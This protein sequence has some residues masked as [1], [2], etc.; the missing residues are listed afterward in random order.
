MLMENWAKE[1]ERAAEAARVQER[2]ACAKLTCVRCKKD[3]FPKKVH[4]GFYHPAHGH[5]Y[6]DVY[7]DG[8]SFFVCR[9]QEIYMRGERKENKNADSRTDENTV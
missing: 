4:G 6:C 2:L 9:A 3:G 5:G 8:E 7:I 1:L